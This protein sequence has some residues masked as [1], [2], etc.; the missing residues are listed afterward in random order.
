MNQRVTGQ[1]CKE[2]DPLKHASQGFGQPQTRLGEFAADVE[3]AHQDGGEDDAH[4]MQA[5]HVG[6]DDGR[7][8]I[9]HRNVRRQLPD[10]SRCFKSAREPCETTGQQ[11]GGP[12]G[13]P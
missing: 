11:E 9:A 1:Q 12:E 3:H 6:D 7:E 2:Q 4:W 8:P 13:R 5:A 10:R